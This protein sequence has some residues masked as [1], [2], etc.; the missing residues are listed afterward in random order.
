MERIIKK[1]NVIGD[2][3]F[4]HHTLSDGNGDVYKIDPEVHTQYEIYYLISGKISYVIEG[5]TYDPA[6]GD[7]IIV[8]PNEVHALRIDGRTPYERAVLLFDIGLLRELLLKIG[9]SDEEFLFG[10]EG[11]LHIISGKTVEKY[12]LGEALIAVTEADGDERYR[13]LVTVARIL[14]FLARLDEMAR[15]DGMMQT[16]PT[17]EDELIKRAVAYVDL[18]IGERITLDDMAAALF[19][20]KS[21]LCHRFSRYMGISI[22]KYVNVRKIHRAH[23]LMRRG[24]TASEAASRVG[25][26]N[27]AAFFYNYKSITGSIPKDIK[28]QIKP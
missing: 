15:C 23:T 25:F 16:P 17:S 13:K 2:D 10:K 21:T 26:D 6:P 20:S 27:Y 4:Y 7:I 14:E 12:R 28:R 24:L 3:L 1:Y 5:K 22:N 19:V 18:H 11:G 8:A 9:I